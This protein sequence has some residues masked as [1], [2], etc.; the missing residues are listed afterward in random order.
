MFLKV[1][2]VSCYQIVWMKKNVYMFYYM[3]FKSNI[4]FRLSNCL[5]NCLNAKYTIQHR[6]ERSQTIKCIQYN[7]HDTML[8]ELPKHII[9][10]LLPFHAK[11][12]YTCTH[13]FHMFLKVVLLS[14]Y[15][16]VWMKNMRKCFHMFFKSS[17]G[18]GLSN[19]LNA[20]KKNKTFGMRST[21][22]NIELSVH[23]QPSVFNT[24]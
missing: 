20:K 2:F 22:Y 12:R 11:I 1:L 15:Q 9:L 14:C 24:T 19:C 16:I 4:G 10:I 21:Q 8:C 5:S 7:I 23:K 3:F 13:F 17:V 6:I 18:V